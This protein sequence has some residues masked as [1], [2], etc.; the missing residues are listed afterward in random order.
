LRSAQ[1][2]D[3]LRIEQLED[4][5]GQHAEVNVVDVH[6]DA[7]LHGEVRICLADAANEDGRHLPE[8][9]SA[10]GQRDVRREIRGIVDV[11]RAARIE[12]LGVECR[13][14]NRRLLNVLRTELRGDDDLLEP[15]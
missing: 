8:A 6:A 15:L 13:D 4:R 11:G 9:G 12:H 5:A 3:A 14:R 7:G 1:H 2:F 10:A